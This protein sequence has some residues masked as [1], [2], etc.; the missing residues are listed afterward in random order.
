MCPSAPRVCS[1]PGGQRLVLSL[2]LDLIGKPKK[3][4]VAFNPGTAHS[5]EIQS[6]RIWW[7]AASPILNDTPVVCIYKSYNRTHVVMEIVWQ[8]FSQKYQYLSIGPVFTKY[9]Y[10]FIAPHSLVNLHNIIYTVYFCS[11]FFFKHVILGFITRPAGTIQT[12]VMVRGVS[13]SWSHEICTRWC[14]FFL[15]QSYIFFFWGIFINIH[16]GRLT[17]RLPQCQSSN[18]EGYRWNRPLPH[19]SPWVPGF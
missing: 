1:E 13:A 18:L 3:T 8:S 17:R 11:C 5:P 10:L 7:G 19:T 6:Y 2:S 4:K 15:L 16:H 9:Q 12:G 14:A